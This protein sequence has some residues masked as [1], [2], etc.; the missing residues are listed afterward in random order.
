MFAGINTL[1]NIMARF[2]NDSETDSQITHNERLE[3]LGD[4]VV[5]FLTS[6]HL[7]HLFPHLEEGTCTTFCLTSRKVPVP[8]SASPRG[9]YLYHLFSHLEEGTCFPPTPYTLC[10]FHIPCR[11]SVSFSF[12]KSINAQNTSFPFARYFSHT[13]QQTLDPC[14]LYPA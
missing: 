2:G 6:I 14:T 9:R 10:I 7:Y 5:E 3:F 11:P 13:L 1:I 8:P 4:A 12:F